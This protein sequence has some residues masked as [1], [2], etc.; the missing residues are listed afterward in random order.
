MRTGVG[1]ERDVSLEFILTVFGC[2]LFFEGIPYFL[3]PLSL[4]RVMV[5][6]VQMDDAVLR[7]IGFSL[8]V[9]GLIMV[10]MVRYFWH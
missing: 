5:Q 6:V 8:M 2:V 1:A 7:R 10:A 9:C 3:S 4:K